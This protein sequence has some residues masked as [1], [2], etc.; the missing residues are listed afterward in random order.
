[1]SLDDKRILLDRIIEYL[2]GKMART[3]K[4]D[5][6]CTLQEIIDTF[7]EDEKRQYEFFRHHKFKLEF[8]QA[9]Q[10]NPKVLFN[11]TSE[12]FTLKKRFRNVQHLLKVLFEEKIGVLE[13]Q[14]LYD[15]IKKEDI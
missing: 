10:N 12:T 4:I 11:L 13:D 15:D 7:N 3:N 9:I 5:V 14:D 1:M 8:A 2:R 6:S